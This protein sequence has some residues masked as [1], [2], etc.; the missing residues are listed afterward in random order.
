MLIFG[1]ILDTIG[2]NP[3]VNIPM[4]QYKTFDTLNIGGAFI[5]IFILIFIVIQ[6]RDH[7]TKVNAQQDAIEEVKKTNHDKK[8]KNKQASTVK[9]LRSSL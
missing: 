4:T 9:T 2:Y 3:K 5:A 7:T 1:L 8:R 6:R